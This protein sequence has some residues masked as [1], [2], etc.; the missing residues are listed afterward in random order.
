MEFFSTLNISIIAGI[1]TLIE[2]V[3]YFLSKKF[4]ISPD[5]WKIV[6]IGA[7]IIGALIVTDW[8]NFVIQTFVQNAIMYSAAST[9]FYQTGKVVITSVKKDETKN[10]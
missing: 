7:G 1:I 5:V 9:L 8:S 2:L 4:I 10:V 6:V 3:K